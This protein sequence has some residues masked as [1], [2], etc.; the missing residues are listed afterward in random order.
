MFR[1][2]YA[3]APPTKAESFHKASE[4][5][6]DLLEGQFP[7]P[8]GLLAT[9]QYEEMFRKVQYEYFFN[10]SA[11][12]YLNP[13]LNVSHAYGADKA[14]YRAEALITSMDP[15][16][17]KAERRALKIAFIQ[18]GIDTYYMLTKGNMTFLE[19]GGHGHGRWLPVIYAA[20]AL[21][22]KP[23]GEFAFRSSRVRTEPN[24]IRHFGEFD[25]F[26]PGVN[27]QLLYGNDPA[28]GQDYW[29]CYNGGNGGSAWAY[30]DPAGLIDGGNDPGSAYMAIITTALTHLVYA[31]FFHSIL[32][33]FIDSRFVWYVIR[34]AQ[35][36]AITL[37][38]QYSSQ[39]PLMAA[40]DRQRHYGHGSPVLLA[41]ALP[42]V[43][44]PGISVLRV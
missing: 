28:Y 36:G 23:M 10:L 39:R 40:K 18:L 17:P 32:F 5:N 27:G 19:G 42:L 1:P 38:D 21:Q 12:S 4:A 8:Q 29:S 13:L 16:I 20:W 9:S 37:P 6:L 25:F 26:V 33:Q 24:A 15:S 44:A 31:A 43:G 11:G 2:P 3:G 14:R 35:R 30:K 34:Y 22:N 41:A 7:R